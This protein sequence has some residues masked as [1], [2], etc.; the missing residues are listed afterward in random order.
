LRETGAESAFTKLSKYRFARNDLQA[1]Q[2]AT[3]ADCFEKK[4]VLKG[5]TESLNEK[6][7]S[8]SLEFPIQI[9]TLA[10]ASLNRGWVASLRNHIL[11]AERVSKPAG[12]EYFDQGRAWAFE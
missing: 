5:Y 1:G 11:R 3:V 2:S 4:K 12:N 10:G 8:F 9:S 7:G 6:G